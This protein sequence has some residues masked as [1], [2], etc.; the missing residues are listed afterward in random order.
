MLGR[1]TFGNYQNPQKSI[2]VALNTNMILFFTTLFRN[3]FG[4]S[5]H[6][7]R[8]VKIF[9]KTQLRIQIK[10]LLLFTNSDQK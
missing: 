4:Y 8:Q 3:N 1:S 6:L 10:C 5:K 7:E 9:S 2:H